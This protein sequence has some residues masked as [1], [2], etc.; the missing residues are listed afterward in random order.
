MERIV[1]S[2]VSRSYVF[3]QVENFLRSI[4]ELNYMKRRTNPNHTGLECA[5]LVTTDDIDTML[6]CY[7]DV[8]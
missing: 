1:I 4:F 7:N 8:F 5:H 3:W 2:D 6:I